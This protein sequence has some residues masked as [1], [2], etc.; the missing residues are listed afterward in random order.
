MA[1]RSTERLNF[2]KIKEITAPPNLIELQTDSYEEFLQAGL[3]PS[4]RQNMGL[5]AVFT[6]VFPIESYDGKCRLEFKEYE[7]GNPKISWLNCLREGLTFGAPLDAIRV[8]FQV[9]GRA[10]SRFVVPISSRRPFRYSA[11]IA[12]TTSSV[13]TASILALIGV[14]SAPASLV[15]VSRRLRISNASSV[16]IVV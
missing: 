1:T 16:D 12:A 5:Q 10:A 8:M 13:T 15:R 11:A 14:V 7:I 6:E 3:S 4:K 9:T 2:G